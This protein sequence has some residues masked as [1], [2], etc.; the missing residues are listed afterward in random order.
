MTVTKSLGQGKF[1]A[2]IMVRT[3]TGEEVTS[4]TVRDHV[5]YCKAR[6]AAPRRGDVISE[7][8]VWGAGSDEKSNRGL[9][10]VRNDP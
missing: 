10:A 2:V 5:R 3:K 9:P 4:R 7:S 6:A 1:G 8:T